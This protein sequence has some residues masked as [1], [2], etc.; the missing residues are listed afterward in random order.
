MFS[1]VAYIIIIFVLWRLVIIYEDLQY[2][3]HLGPFYPLTI[4][5]QKSSAEIK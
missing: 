5:A 3:V 2:S 4:R 1:R